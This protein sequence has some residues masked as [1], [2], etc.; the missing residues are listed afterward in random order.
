MEPVAGWINNTD[1]PTGI[2]CGTEMGI[3]HT[4][5]LD[6]D[7]HVELVPADFVCNLVLTATWS[8]AKTR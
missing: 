7:C 2:L 1:G 3:L 4:F 5:Y 6:A 8:I